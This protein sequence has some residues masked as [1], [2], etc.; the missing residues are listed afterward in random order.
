MFAVALAEGVVERA[1]EPH[2][3][4]VGGGLHPRAADRLVRNHVH[5][6]LHIHGRLQRVAVEFAVALCRMAVADIEERAGDIHA[7]GRRSRLPRFR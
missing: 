7:A 1:I 6:E 3:H 4:D 5:G 2:G